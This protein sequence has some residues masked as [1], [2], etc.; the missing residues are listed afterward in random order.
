MVGI[1]IEI[2]GLP[3]PLSRA[4][5]T[6]KSF[7]DP[8]YMA[9][10]NFSHEVQKQFD[11]TFKPLECPL[12]IELEFHL[13]IPTSISNKKK[14]LLFKNGHAKKP[15]LSNLIKF[16]EDALNKVIWQDDSLICEVI[17]K[18]IYTYEPKTILTIKEKNGSE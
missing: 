10:K 6:N 14:N 13:P 16:V 17:A 2:T 8:Q 11:P 7:Y 9:K 5:V 1:R 15:D 18:K 12:S 4:R 3:L